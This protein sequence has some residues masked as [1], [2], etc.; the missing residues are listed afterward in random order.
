MHDHDHGSTSA[1]PQPRERYVGPAAFVL[2]L[3]GAT[4]AILGFYLFVLLSLLVLLLIVAVDFSLLIAV[5][6]FGGAVFF[7]NILRRHIHVLM[8]FLRSLWLGKSRNFRIALKSDDAPGFAALLK[9]VCAGAKVRMPNKVYLVMGV[10]A[11]VQMK[12]FWRG[13]GETILGVG[14]DLLAGLSQ[15]EM[16]GVLAHEMMHAKLVQRG[17]RQLLVGGLGRAARLARGLRTQIHAQRRARQSVML[18]EVF[19]GPADSLTRLAARQI[20]AC[21]RQD[22]FE[23]DRGAAE[24]CGASTLMTSLRK[25]EGLEHIVRRLPLREKVARLESGDGLSRWL[26]NELASAAPVEEAHVREQAFNRY[27]THPSMHDRLAALAAFPREEPAH[28]PPAIDLLSHPDEVAEKLVK[29]IQKELVEQEQEDS[30]QLT[31]WSRRFGRSSDLNPVQAIGYLM[32]IGAFLF[33]PVIFVA[34]LFSMPSFA[35]IKSTS[36]NKIEVKDEQVKEIEAEFSRIKQA[37]RKSRQTLTILIEQCYEALQRCDYLRAH[38]AARLALGSDKNSVPATL[39]LA[40]AA[41]GL[42]QGQQVGRAIHFIQ[43]RTGFRGASAAWGAG[44]GLALAS[45]WIHAEAFLERARA[46][47]PQAATILALLAICQSRRGKLFTAIASARS[48]VALEPT[49][50]E[51]SKLLIDLLLQAGSLREA[52]ALLQPLA[53]VALSDSELML[54]MVKLCLLLGDQATADQWIEWVRQSSDGPKKFVSL[55]EAFEAARRDE[56]A[57]EYFRAALEQGHFPEALLG[58]AR[59]EAN[60]HRSAE[61]T[62]HLLAALDLNRPAGEKSVGAVP[63]VGAILKQLV[64]LQEPV[65][66]CRAWTAALPAKTNPA[67]LANTRFLVFA[68]NDTTAKQSL[69]TILKAMIPG[70]ELPSPVSWLPAPREQQPDGLVHPGV[71]VVLN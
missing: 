25:L 35:L 41:G 55:A 40:V 58:L 59:L 17:F 43:R 7:V 26:V 37:G 65:P 46:R 33:C 64:I 45:D 21:S 9:K 20:A 34:G 36:Q 24:L 49:E 60:A 11:W 27:S 47:K 31:A 29:A 12:G 51:L 13:S 54:S 10:N 38:I 22:E 44:W 67:V 14:Y 52:S 6:R 48:A 2:L 4:C 62:S 19:A 57:A 39:G 30:R 15:G 61:A 18:L 70:M 53:S 28:S 63:L 71:Q 42:R 23:A 5:A 16:E 8:I 69:D 68:Q 66:N 56:K 3:A 50:I 32:A 1:S